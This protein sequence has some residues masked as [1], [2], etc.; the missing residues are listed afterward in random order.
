MCCSTEPT[1][2]YDLGDL[3]FEFMSH[4]ANHRKDDKAREDACRAIADR[5]NESIPKIVTSKYDR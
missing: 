3:Q 2:V 1:L 5:N 4:V